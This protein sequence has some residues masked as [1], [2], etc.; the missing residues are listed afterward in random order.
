MHLID[1]LEKML[2]SDIDMRDVA[3]SLELTG[4]LAIS[5]EY[6]TRIAASATILDRMNATL[7]SHSTS[8]KE[9]ERVLDCIQKICHPKVAAYQSSS[10]LTEVG[11]NS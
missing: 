1:A 9:K 2:A 5:E 7:T 10:V 8:S 11:C 4:H 6:Q 3:L